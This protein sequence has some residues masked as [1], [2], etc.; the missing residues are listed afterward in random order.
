MSK[1]SKCACTVRSVLFREYFLGVKRM[2]I[3][4]GNWVSVVFFCYL[5]FGIRR[6]ICDH[7]V[8]KGGQFSSFISSSGQRTRRNLGAKILSQKRS[9][10]F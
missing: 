1:S 6:K 5:F 4:G 8:K 10:P 9:S 2:R 7:F 3:V